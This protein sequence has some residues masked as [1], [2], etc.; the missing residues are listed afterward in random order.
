[1]KYLVDQDIPRYA[2]ELLRARS[3]EA[4]HVKECGHRLPL[5]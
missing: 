5:P 1:M 4:A 2:A 3:V